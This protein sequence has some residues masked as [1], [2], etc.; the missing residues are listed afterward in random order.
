MRGCMTTFIFLLV[1]SSMLSFVL[2]T[3]FLLIMWIDPQADGP[4]DVQWY[5]SVIVLAYLIL[6]IKL[7]VKMSRAISNSIC[8]FLFGKE[9]EV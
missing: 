9:D 5:T 6:I 4:F 2:G 7:M 8:N 1:S 3:V